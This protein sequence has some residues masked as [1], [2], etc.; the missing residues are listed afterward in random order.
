MF[1]DGIGLIDKQRLL[2]GRPKFEENRMFYFRY[3]KMGKISFAIKNGKTQEMLMNGSAWEI[4]QLCDGKKTV[5]N[6]KELYAKRYSY[7]ETS[8]DFLKD[9]AV[10]LFVFDK[11]WALSWGK[12]GSPF[13]LSGKIELSD[14][15]T[16]EWAG[17]KDIR[18]IA[19]TYTQYVE[20]D[21]YTCHNTPDNRNKGLSDYQNETILRSKLFYYKEDFFLLKNF[22][23][24]VIGIISV[25]NNQ[26]DTDNLEISTIIVP[27]KFIEMS[28]NGLKSILQS[29]YPYNIKKIRIKVIGNDE[30]NCMTTCLN[31]CGYEKVAVLKEEYGPQR[32]LCV[33]DIVM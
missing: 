1:Y 33:Y 9:I 29:N 11:L 12:G 31:K 8:V 10:T 14:N 27:E 22:E 32:D 18:I 21:A 24:K 13:M 15:Y 3:E 30:E 2:L 28:L 17:E 25:S 20:E 23:D 7:L 6:I 5:E 19:E 16:F 4:L 26:P